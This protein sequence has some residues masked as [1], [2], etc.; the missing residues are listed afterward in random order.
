MK[1]TVGG[2]SPS[3]RYEK[4]DTGDQQAELWPFQSWEQPFFLLADVPE[5]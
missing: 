5:M 3:V 2:S 1:A 4:I